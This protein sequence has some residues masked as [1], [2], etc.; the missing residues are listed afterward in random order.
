M[1]AKAKELGKET[2]K[3]R[4]RLF[5][6]LLMD[7]RLTLNV[8]CYHMKSS[9]GGL[10]ADA[11]LKSIKARNTPE[12]S[13]SSDRNEARKKKKG[14]NAKPG[15]TKRDPR[16]LE[17]EPDDMDKFNLKDWEKPEKNHKRIVS[18]VYTP[19]MLC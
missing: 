13:S 3:N 6:T 10:A 19:L 17:P 1:R 2:Q 16:D 18:Y 15:T 8:Y 14:K 12:I 5:L 7:R 11:H 4:A 9:A